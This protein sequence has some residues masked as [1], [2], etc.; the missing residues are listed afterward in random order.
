MR[1]VANI[2]KGKKDKEFVSSLTPTL[3]WD[4]DINTIDAQKHA[5]YIVDRVL[6]R[7]RMED[8]KNTLAYYGKEKV[9]E[10][11]TH[12]RYLDK[13]VLAFCIT[14]FNIPKNKFRCYTER[15]LHPTHWSY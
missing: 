10:I 9:G 4:T 3:F 14:Y 8:F 12:L 13:I 6:Q 5:P 11:A 7:G 1:K 15:Q 2:K